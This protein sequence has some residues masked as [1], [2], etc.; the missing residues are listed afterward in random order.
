MKKKMT[1]SVHLTTS[2]AARAETVYDLLADLESHLEWAGKRQTRDFRLT[3]LDA[4]AGPAQVGT[5]FSSRGLIPMSRHTWEDMSTVTVADRP[6]VFEFVTEGQGG[7]AKRMA[8][9]WLNRYEIQP[10][11]DGCRIS[12]QLSLLRVTNPFLRLSMPGFRNLTWKIG[13]PQ[14]SSRGLRNLAAMAEEREGVGTM[15]TMS[16]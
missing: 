12:Y 9:Q 16:S 10:G 2:C 13:I 7:G 4:P 5:V 3:M 6:R 8:S 14:V 1:P 11:D 15:T